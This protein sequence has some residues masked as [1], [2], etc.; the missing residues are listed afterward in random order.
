M[1]RNIELKYEFL[2]FAIFI[3]TLR[4]K[5]NLLYAVL[6]TLVVIFTLKSYP[7]FSEIIFGM[8][9]TLIIFDTINQHY[10]EYKFKELTRKIKANIFS[11]YY[12]VYEIFCILTN[13]FSEK[14]RNIQKETII[15]G[16]KTLENLVKTVQTKNTIDIPENNLYI[17]RNYMKDLQQ[18]VKEAITLTEKLGVDFEIY[19]IIQE[20]D[21]F[22]KII[23]FDINNKF[24]KKKSS[25]LELLFGQLNNSFLKDLVKN[26]NILLTKLEENIFLK[27]IAFT[28]TR[29][30]HTAP[31]KIPL[32]KEQTIALN[33]RLKEKHDL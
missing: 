24:N 26:Y 20:L 21:K 4:L 10:K 14:T 6:L 7:T 3:L 12:C 13:D 16:A 17:L 25:S 22:N 5:S 15:H 1:M 32:T 2:T 28:A 8:I 18:N 30:V 9:L 19:N 23:N 11:S 33:K 27:H 29:S 31:C